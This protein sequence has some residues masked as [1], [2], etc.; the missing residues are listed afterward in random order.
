VRN[1]ITAAISGVVGAVLAVVAAWAVVSSSTA[2]PDHN[3]AGQQ[4]VEYGQR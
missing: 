4:V 1:W 2:A 3:P